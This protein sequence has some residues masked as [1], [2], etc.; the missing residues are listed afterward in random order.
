MDHSLTERKIPVGLIIVG[1]L[2]FVVGGLLKYGSNV[3]LLLAFIG[4][5]TVVG[6]LLMLIA[7]Y[8]TAMVCS[9]SFGDLA[10]AALKLAGI[11][12]FSSALGAFLPSGYGFLLRTTVFVLLMMWLFDL[13]L[14]YVIAF[15]AVNFVV[16][17]LA[18]FAIAAVLVET[19]KV[20]LK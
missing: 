5:S 17:L 19:G 20:G 2:I 1:E 12:I 7:A 15:T 10:S 4:I 14:T 3:G 13:E 8:V 18:A 9:I 6:T 16:S 11:Y